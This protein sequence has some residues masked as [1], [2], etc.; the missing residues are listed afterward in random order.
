MS[1]TT[2]LL[3]F[4]PSAI[5]ARRRDSEVEKLRE[6]NQT[7]RSERDALQTELERAWRELAIERDSNARR[8][9]REFMHQ[10]ATMLQQAM[11]AQQLNQ[12]AAVQ[13]GMLGM[14]PNVGLGQWQRGDYCNCVPDR[15]Q[16]FGQAL[17]EPAVY[18]RPEWFGGEFPP[19]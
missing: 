3:A 11:Q 2:L 17:G 5:A 10:Q 12:Q 13:L 9:Q 7:L 8:Q 1:L 4:A 6:E 16:L 18:I 14:Q 15:A 19:A